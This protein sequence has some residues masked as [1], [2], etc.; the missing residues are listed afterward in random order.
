MR[1]VIVPDTW[2]PMSSAVEIML[3]LAPLTR[4]CA[5]AGVM[6]WPTSWPQ[7]HHA[8]GIRGWRSPMSFNKTIAACAW[9][10]L[11]WPSASAQ[12]CTQARPPR[13]P[14][15]P[16]GERPLLARVQNRS[17]C[18]RTFPCSPSPKR[19]ARPPGSGRRAAHSPLR[20]APLG[21]SAFRFNS[22]CRR[23]ALST[24]PAT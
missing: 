7:D 5:D 10:Q 13:R 17:S 21:A 23:A 9:L 24:T 8:N 11:S 22:I 6:T 14:P 4:L 18:R 1:N 12:Q 19:D 16:N 3:K 2:L 20:Y 15:L